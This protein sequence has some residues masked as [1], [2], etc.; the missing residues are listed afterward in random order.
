MPIN[1]CRKGKRVE[2]E[3]AALGLGTAALDNAIEQAR[4]DARDGAAPVG[5]RDAL[6][7]AW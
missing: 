1:S 3:A 6:Y 5:H 4:R 7:E 2:R